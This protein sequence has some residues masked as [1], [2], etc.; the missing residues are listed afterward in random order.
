MF[1]HIAELIVPFFLAVLGCTGHP[2]GPKHVRLLFLQRG[3]LG[4]ASHS[5][6]AICKSCLPLIP[7]RTFL[8]FFLL[9]FLFPLSTGFSACVC[10][11]L[12]CKE[13]SFG[14]D[15]LEV[16]PLVPWIPMLH[17]WVCRLIFHHF[18]SQPSS[19]MSLTYRVLHIA[20]STWLLTKN[21]TRFEGYINLTIPKVYFNWEVK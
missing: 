9:T 1:S 6:D 4:S 10:F 17:I 18:N 2:Q 11:L 8:P 15:M 19:H 20:P 14:E 5:S 13:N 16:P 12:P 3:T 7:V 21:K